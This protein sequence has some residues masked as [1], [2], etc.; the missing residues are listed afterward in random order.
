MSFNCDMCGLNSMPNT[1]L[2]KEIVNTRKKKYFTMV[3]RK[4]L[5]KRENQGL[6][7]KYKYVFLYK[8]NEKTIQELLENKYELISEKFS[9]G[10]EI[11]KENQICS[12]C[13]K[14]IGLK[15]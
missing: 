1:R 9:E 15:N 11:V 10:N 2:Y 6:P 8:R 5:K 14:I 4:L 13:A 7:N 12:S 3:F